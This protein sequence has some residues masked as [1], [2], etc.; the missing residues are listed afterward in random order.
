MRGVPSAVSE[1]SQVVLVRHNG[2]AIGL[3]VEDLHGVPEFDAE[4]IIPTPL[5]AGE[6]GMLVTHVIKANGGDLLIQVINADF[7]FA[8][9]N[10]PDA[11]Q[12]P[13]LPAAEMMQELRLAA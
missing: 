9:L 11:P 10:D 3:L 12:A 8:Y 1:S 5:A 6:D 7:L 2:Q 4:Q 13:L